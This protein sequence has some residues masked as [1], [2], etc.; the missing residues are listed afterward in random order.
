M[1]RHR[2]FERPWHRRTS[3]QVHHGVDAVRDPVQRR[4]IQ[5]A[6]L[7]ELDVHVMQVV[8]GAG[9]E[10]VQC[11]DADPAVACEQGTEIGPD[12]TG[13]A[14]NQHAHLSRPFQFDSSVPASG[15]GLV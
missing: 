2:V 13:S 12:E 15:A 7:D 6:A 1:G 9:G 4:G 10:V 11:R 5:D 14:G 3:R 8:E